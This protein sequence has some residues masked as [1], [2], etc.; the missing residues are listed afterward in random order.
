MNPKDPHIPFTVEEPDQEVSQ[1]SWI[2]WFL[3]V[4][5]HPHYFSIQKTHTHD[6]Y[7]HWDSNHLVMAKHSVFNTLAHRAKVVSTNQQSLQKELKHIRALQACSFPTWALNSLHQFNCKHIIHNGQNSTN[8][9]P[10][11]NNNNGTSNHNNNNKNIFIV[12]PYIHGLEEEFQRTCNRKGI[13]VHL[14]DTNT[15]KPSS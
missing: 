11:D 10:N 4:P 1:P 9:Q 3:Q 12:V 14:K 7:L 5:Q 13:Q 15:I 6:Q 8:N 2:P